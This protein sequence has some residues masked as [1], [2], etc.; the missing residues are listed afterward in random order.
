MKR[1]LAALS[2]LSARERDRRDAQRSRTATRHAPSSASTPPRPSRS[3][4]RERHLDPRRPGAGRLLRVANRASSSRT[5]GFVSS[6]ASGN[7]FSRAAV[8]SRRA[9]SLRALSLRDP[10]LPPAIRRA[11]VHLDVRGQQLHVPCGGH[12]LRREVPVRDALRLP[13]GVELRARLDR[14]RRGRPGPDPASPGDLGVRALSGTASLRICGLVAVR[15]GGYYSKLRASR[16]SLISMPTYEFRCPDGHDFERFFRSISTVR[17]PDCLSGVRPDR[18]TR[19]VRRRRP[20]LQG[21]GLLH[22]RLRQGRQGRR[23]P[24]T[25]RSDGKRRRESASERVGRRARHRASERSSSGD[26]AKSDAKPSESVQARSKAERRRVSDGLGRAPRRADARRATTRRARAVEPLL[27][28]PRDPS[29]GDW[30]TNLAMTL[31][32]PLGAEAARHRA[33][34]SSTRSTCSAA[35]VREAEIAGPGFINFRLDA[36]ARRGGHRGARR[37]GRAVRPYD[38]GARPRRQRR[39]RVGQSDRTAARRARPAGRA[40]RR[41]R[42]AARVDRVEVTREFYYNDAGA[43]I[44][45]L[46][47]SVQAR[48]R[49]LARRD[50]SRFPKAATTASTSARSPQRVRRRASRRRR[51]ATT[52]TRCARSRCRRCARSRTSTCRRS[53]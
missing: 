19:D 20:A 28:R 34:S 13:T 10:T 44:E 1:V 53:A 9:L 24:P 5:V 16:L 45:N 2:P 48:V 11:A 36:G 31:A 23:R 8:R 4:Q 52:S 35:G 38:D 37:G 41:D 49:E 18:R 22:H 50:R 43:Q 14:R 6:N 39:V 46:A 33:A 40:R 42:V 27:E 29:F 47:L 17:S 12:R 3:T 30:A 21:I 15:A 7:R 32:K 26:S 25:R 51:T